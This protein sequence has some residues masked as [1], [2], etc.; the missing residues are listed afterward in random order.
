M[1]SPVNATINA[2][3]AVPDAGLDT[4][5]DV[6]HDVPS[7]PSMN[8]PLPT[9]PSGSNS[10][11]SSEA[12]MFAQ[13][14][15]T[16]LAADNN[17]NHKSIS[18]TGK[19]GAY[20]ALIAGCVMAV[21]LWWPLGDL[22]DDH[23]PSVA[24]LKTLTDYM[25]GEDDTLSNAWGAQSE[26]FKD[27]TTVLNKAQQNLVGYLAKKYRIAGSEVRKMVAAA[28]SAGAQ[29]KLDPL[30]ILAVMS[31]ESNL[32]PIVESA[33]GAQGLMQIMPKV[34]ALRFS[35]YGGVDNIFNIE[36]NVLIGARILVDCIKIGGNTVEGGLKCYV[37]ATGPTDGGYGAKVIAEQDR[38][39]RATTGNADVAP[40]KID[41]ELKPSTELIPLLKPEKTED[42]VAQ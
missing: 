28:Y 21:A 24:L 15:S 39:L 25:R 11:S 32:N 33:A 20:V 34:H 37:G 10:A 2:S 8:Q 42:L 36:T 6:A 40:I 19:M 17:L 16:T 22:E 5:L 18:L 9:V 23:G 27:K 35:A 30:L 3:N 26:Q 14:S 29:T 12:S 41:L 1:N 4:G 7:H 31:I 38:L 13:G